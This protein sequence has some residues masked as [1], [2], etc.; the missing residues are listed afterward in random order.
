MTC[1]LVLIVLVV[2][3]I[4]HASEAKKGAVKVLNEASFEHQ[5]Q[6]ATGAT[7]GDWFVMFSDESCAYCRQTSPAF[8]QLALATSGE[9]LQVSVAVVSC[10]DDDSQWVCKR[11]GVRSYPT[12]ALFRRGKMYEYEGKRD[13]DS[14]LAFL[15]DDLRTSGRIP[16]AEFG[17]FDKMLSSIMDVQRSDPLIFYITAALTAITVVLFCVLLCIPAPKVRIAAGKK[18]AGGKQAPAERKKDK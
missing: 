9:G 1:S 3:L 14:M 17:V 6:A 2:C 7:T 5:T 11:F 10:S 15:T 13:K 8:E 4:V 16:P 18:L 12:F